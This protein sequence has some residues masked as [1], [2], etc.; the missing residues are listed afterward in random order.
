MHRS[1]HAGSSQ[2]MV[3]RLS[4]RT[5]SGCQ[6]IL[7]KQSDNTECQ[8]EHTSH[9]QHKQR[10]GRPFSGKN[11]VNFPTAGVFTTFLRLD[12]CLRTESAY[13]E[14]P[15]VRHRRG[16]IQPALL[17]QLPDDMPH[18]ILLVLRQLQRLLD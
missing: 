8:I 16:A 14:K 12:H 11:P 9:N 10:N 17:L 1:R 15:H 5:N 7:Q 13:K 3:Y 2:S 4:Q 6:K 18:R